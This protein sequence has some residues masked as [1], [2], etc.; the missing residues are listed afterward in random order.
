M[1][2]YICPNCSR[3]YDPLV[4]SNLFDPRT[5]TFMCE[6]CKIEIIEHDPATKGTG[7][8]EKM[9]AFN[10][11]TQP[12]RDALKRLEGLTL[13]S[14]NIMAW[15]AQNVK[16]EI[17]G[18]ESTEGEDKKFQV[19][20]GGEEKEQL[21]KE[22]L[23][24]AQRCVDTVRSGLMTVFKTLYPSGTLIRPSL[25][26]LLHLEYRVKL[27][28]LRYRPMVPGQVEWEMMRM[29]TICWKR[30]TLKWM[31]MMNNHR[32]RKFQRAKRLLHLLLVKALRVWTRSWSWVSQLNYSFGLAEQAVNGVPKPIGE[33]DD[34][35]EAHMTAE[36]YEVSTVLPCW[37]KAD[38]PGVRRCD[39]GCLMT[40]QDTSMRGIPRINCTICIT[41][42]CQAS[43]SK[44]KTEEHL[45]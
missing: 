8:Q 12:I 42:H 23:A 24:E 22:R 9:Q 25:E 44:I 32:K 30:I 7:G 40:R 13:P 31:K 10:I 41:Q 3:E 4:V 19:V 28:K 17:V 45:Y 34:N 27:V 33:I 26:P 11:A 18:V 38:S 20:L 5:N 14:R 1:R 6:D 39:G 15:I 35:D 43:I 21:E 2:G 36:E 37:I 16:S 29:R